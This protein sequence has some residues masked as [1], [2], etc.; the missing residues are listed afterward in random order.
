MVKS[1]FIILIVLLILISCSI[2]K[3]GVFFKEMSQQPSIEIMDNKITIITDNSF[4]NS[5]LLIYKIK[6]SVDTIKRVLN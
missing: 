5:A 6:I 3:K 1:R 4:Q 2:G